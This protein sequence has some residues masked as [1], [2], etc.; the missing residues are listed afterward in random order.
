MA[1]TLYIIQYMCI[2][3]A[4]FIIGTALFL[5]PFFDTLFS[6]EEVPFYEIMQVD[7]EIDSFSSLLA[8]QMFTWRVEYPGAS[9]AGEAVDVV[10]T[11]YVSQKELAGIV[12]LAEVRD[13]CCFQ[14]VIF[15]LF[16]NRSCC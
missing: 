15:E 2:Y 11:L 6:R 10:S 12:P 5:I 8:T 7:F 1:S 4:V 3:K 13:P 9:M 16:V 14:G